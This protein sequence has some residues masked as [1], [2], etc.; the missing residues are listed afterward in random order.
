MNPRFLDAVSMQRLRADEAGTRGWQPATLNLARRTGRLPRRLPTAQL[1]FMLTIGFAALAV[2]G[3]AAGIAEVMTD[4]ANVGA[5]AWLRLAIAS[6]LVGTVVANVLAMVGRTRIVRWVG[7][8]IGRH[9]PTAPAVVRESVPLDMVGMAELTRR[10]PQDL[11]RPA[12]RQIGSARASGLISR[13]SWWP[14]LIAAFVVAATGVVIGGYLL[15]ESVITHGLQAALGWRTLLLAFAL[16]GTVAVW[17]IGRRS[18]IHR[19]YRR[20]RPL[21]RRLLVALRLGGRPADTLLNS[22]ARSLAQAAPQMVL[23]SV[24]ATGALLVGG[25][26]ALGFSGPGGFVSAW[27]DA[28][29]TTP[30]PTAD[31]QT[32]GATATALNATT[33]PVS[34]DVRPTDGNATSG[35]VAASATPETNASIAPPGTSPGQSATPV[36]PPPDGP[37]PSTT[38]A[39]QPPTAEPTAAPKATQTSTPTPTPKSTPTPTP[40]VTPPPTPSPSPTPTPTPTPKPTP[41]PCLASGQPDV[42]CDG[43]SNDDEKAYGSDPED[44]ASTPESAAYDVMNNKSTCFDGKDN[45]LDGAFDAKDSECG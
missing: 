21:L 15:L 33:P 18:L 28:A 5:D 2:T 44:P 32:A 27:G 8:R 39:T 30:G 12:A 11:G 24:A 42:D 3:L 6:L 43:V 1:L 37:S 36:S 25:W 34:P 16:L 10:A 4:S 13:L 19:R 7:R 26:S 23:V 40:K 17:R 29:T 9:R 20:R 31:Q 22:G 14:L 38:T 45:D 35:A 41:T